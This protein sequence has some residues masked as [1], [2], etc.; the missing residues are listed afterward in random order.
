MFLHRCAL[1][2]TR[3]HCL[4][5]FEGDRCETNMDDCEDNSC[6]NNAT[7]VDEIQSYSCRCLTGFTGICLG[8]VHPIFDLL[9]WLGNSAE[10]LFQTLRLSICSVVLGA[11]EKMCLP[12]EMKISRSKNRYV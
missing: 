8:L 1:F 11:P 7:C 10:C 6:K 3:C 9:V 5:G 4:D 12:L 2:V